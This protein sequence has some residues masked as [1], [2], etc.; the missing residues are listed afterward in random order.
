[1]EPSVKNQLLQKQLTDKGY[2]LTRQRE[3]VLDLLC[4]S[5]RHADANLLYEQMRK[6]MPRVSLGTV[7]RTLNVLAAAGV[8]CALH[9]GAQAHYDGNVREHYHIMC[10]RCG[11]VEDVAISRLKP[12]EEQAAQLSGYQVSDHQLSFY[13]LCAKCQKESGEQECSAT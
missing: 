6:Q 11:A 2:R 5:A 3:L 1:M 9:C 12:L 13:G 4:T 8:I 7:Y 10:T